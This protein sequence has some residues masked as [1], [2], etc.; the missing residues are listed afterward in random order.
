MLGTDFTGLQDNGAKSMKNM[1]L[2]LWAYRHF[3]FS[4]IKNEVHARFSRSK[5]GALWMI[6]QPLAQSAIYALVLSQLLAARLPGATSAYSYAIYL[7][8][9]MVAWALFNELVTR[10]MAMFVENAAIMKK[11]MFPRICLPVITTGSA[12]LN[13]VLLMLATMFIFALIGHWPSSSLAWLPFLVVVTVCF[14]MALGMILGI[15][16]VFV[17]DVGQAAGVVLQLWF[18]L[19]PVVY[20]IDIVPA[21][22]QKYFAWNPMYHIVKGFQAVLFRGAAPEL[23]GIM[24]ILLGSLVLLV[25]S[26]VLFRR[27]APDM[28]D[29]L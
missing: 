17:R 2:A 28:V 4:S 8:S 20:M 12:L 1:F 25:L 23:Q 21:P 29:V 10:S 24:V 18:W 14:G 22:L 6:L 11:I 9:G 27:A 26:L 19:T 5:L 7:M 13:N 16:N 3:I 15:L